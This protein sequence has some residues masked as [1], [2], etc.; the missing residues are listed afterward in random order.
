MQSVRDTERERR[1]QM[2]TSAQMYFNLTRPFCFQKARPILVENYHVSIT[3]NVYSALRPTI[4]VPWR[5]EVR[6]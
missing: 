2:S 6:K 1:F 3:E 5:Y 4:R